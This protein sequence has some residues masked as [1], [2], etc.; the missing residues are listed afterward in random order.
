M[1]ARRRQAQPQPSTETIEKNP[2]RSQTRLVQHELAHA[3]AQIV[4]H[5]LFGAD[6]MRPVQAAHTHGHDSM[7]LRV[8]RV[9]TRQGALLRDRHE[10]DQLGVVFLHQT[11]LEAHSRATIEQKTLQIHVQ[12]GED[13][14]E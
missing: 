11:R 3:W 12:F 2:Q 14:G 10:Q 6:R 4:A 8:V 1:P 9:Y 13:Q 7:V 5:V